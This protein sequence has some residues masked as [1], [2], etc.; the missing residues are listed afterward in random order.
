MVDCLW[1]IVVQV[2]D[3]VIAIDGQNVDSVQDLVGAVHGKTEVCVR[4]LKLFRFC[5]GHGNGVY[6]NNCVRA[7]ICSCGRFVNTDDVPR[8]ARLATH[9]RGRNRRTHGNSE[10]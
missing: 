4:M 5:N 6:P 2:G 9:H 10:A 8:S 3:V 1:L 7:F